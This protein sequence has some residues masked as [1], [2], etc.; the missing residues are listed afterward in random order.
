ML[1][2]V[3]RRSGNVEERGFGVRQNRVF[4]MHSHVLPVTRAI[5]LNQGLANDFCKGPESE[6]VRLWGLYGLG[7]SLSTPPRWLESSRRWCVNEWVR[8]RGYVPRTLYLQNKRRAWL[9]PQAT[10]RQP[11]AQFSKP[12]CTRHTSSAGRDGVSW[13]LNKLPRWSIWTHSPACETAQKSYFFPSLFSPKC[14]CVV[15]S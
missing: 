7:C 10:V 4:T 12:Q 8:E 3:N 15:R 5:H 2:V 14:F 13:R 6:Y 9:G 11:M 1:D